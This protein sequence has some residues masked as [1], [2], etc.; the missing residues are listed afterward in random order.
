MTFTNTAAIE[1]GTAN[2]VIYL[3]GKVSGNIFTIDSTTVFTC[4]IPTSADGCFYIPL[5]IMYSATAG[6]FQSSKDLYAYIDGKFRQVTPTE[7][8]ATHRIYYRTTAINNSLAAPSTWVDEATANVY[9][10]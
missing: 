5:G 6:Y 1:S 3:K 8:V 9:N 10:T 4:K 2:S 7:I